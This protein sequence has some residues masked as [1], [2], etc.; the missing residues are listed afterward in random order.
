MTPRIAEI[1][2]FGVVG[3]CATLVHLGLLRLGVDRLGL[4]AVVAT[5]IAFCVAVAVTWTGQTLWVFPGVRR[6]PAQ[7]AR[8]GVSVIAGLL[9]NMAIMA[10]AVNVLHLPFEWG[11]A[12]GLIVVPAAT[13]VLNKIWVFA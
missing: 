12:A 2:R 7:A 3:V 4:P 6:G 8:F 10:L 13:Y 9:G 1:L 11:F 5:G